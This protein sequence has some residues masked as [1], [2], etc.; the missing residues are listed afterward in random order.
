M[1]LEAGEQV[2]P[3]GHCGQLL[4]PP[5]TFAPPELHLQDFKSL[6]YLELVFVRV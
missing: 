3:P 4:S 1:S 6:I 2:L 5:A